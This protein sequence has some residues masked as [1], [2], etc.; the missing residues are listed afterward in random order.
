MAFA[1][2]RWRKRGCR[3]GGGGGPMTI[4]ESIALGMALVL[5]IGVRFSAYAS[6]RTGD[7]LTAL[8]VLAIALVVLH[9]AQRQ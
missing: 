4:A 1:S 3:S 7:I 6:S 8:A 5:L 9:Q 2:R